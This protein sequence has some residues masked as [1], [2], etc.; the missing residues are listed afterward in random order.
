MDPMDQPTPRKLFSTVKTFK[1]TV[2]KRVK[3]RAKKP[4]F[5]KRIKLRNKKN[6]FKPE[7][8]PDYIR[9]SPNQSP[10]S[11]CYDPENPFYLSHE[12]AYTKFGA[13]SVININNA[14]MINCATRRWSSRQITLK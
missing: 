4:S 5:E 2:D 6:S 14:G 10:D 7:S 8:K 12:I 1:K 11:C 13:G 3:K 9:F